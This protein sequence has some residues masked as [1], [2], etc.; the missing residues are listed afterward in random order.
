MVINGVI[1][2]DKGFYK[3]IVLNKVGKLWKIF[4]VDFEGKEDDYLEDILLDLERFFFVE[5]KIVVFFEVIDWGDVK[6]EVKV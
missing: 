1:L 2:D 6:F 3:C 5:D 4:I